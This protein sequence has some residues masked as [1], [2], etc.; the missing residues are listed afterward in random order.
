METCRDGHGREDEHAPGSN[1]SRCELKQ[2]SSSSEH[3]RQNPVTHESILARPSPRR[4]VT[5]LAVPL[6]RLSAQVSFLSAQMAAPS[7]GAELVSALE[8]AEAAAAQVADAAAPASAAQDGLD[9]LESLLAA[10]VDAELLAATGLGKRV[11][12][13]AKA[14]EGATPAAT[15]LADKARQVMDAWVAKVKAAT[16]ADEAAAAAEPAAKRPKVEPAAEPRA[17]PPVKREAVAAP[18]PT[19]DPAR[20]KLR[21][22]LT[23]ALELAGACAAA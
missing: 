5:C 3:E 22:L 13:L 10:D 1:N 21:E 11:R 23:A 14:A 18:P 9:A 15:S 4:D 8:R 17:A 16:P 6:A 12:K 20:D 7:A 2:K 19:K